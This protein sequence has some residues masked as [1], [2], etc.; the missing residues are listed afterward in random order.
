MLVVMVAKWIA[1]PIIHPYFDKL[2]ELKNI[3]YL[4]P[5]PSKEMK[6]LMC[7]HIMAKKPDCFAEKET[8]LHISQVCNDFCTCSSSWI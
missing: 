2:I 1:D 8:L 4:E 7:K 6:L 5:S 3:P